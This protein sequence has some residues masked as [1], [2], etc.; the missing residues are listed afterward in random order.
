MISFEALVLIIE[1]NQAVRGDSSVNLFFSSHSDL[2]PPLMLSLEKYLVLPLPSRRIYEFF[3]FLIFHIKDFSTKTGRSETSDFFNFFWG[4]TQPFY[5]VVGARMP[6]PVVSSRWSFFKRTSFHL[7]NRIHTSLGF[8]NVTCVPPDFL[9]SPKTMKI[10]RFLT[11]DSKS[12]LKN[13]RLI[14]IFW[15]GTLL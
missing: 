6:A 14:T 4:V 9:P 12:W 11:T 13:N 3:L 8:R 10:G 5:W 2:A 15:Q 7:K 1:W